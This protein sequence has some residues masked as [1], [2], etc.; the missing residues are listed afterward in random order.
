MPTLQI[1]S[2]CFWD[3]SLRHTSVNY[4]PASLGAK[5]CANYC[6]TPPYISVLME[7]HNLWHILIYASGDLNAIILLKWDLIGQLL[8]RLLLWSHFFECPYIVSIMYQRPAEQ[9]SSEPRQHQLYFSQ[10][11]SST[12][13]LSLI[14]DVGAEIFGTSYL[15]VDWK[16]AHSSS[17]ILCGP[18]FKEYSPWNTH[19]LFLCFPPLVKACV[20]IKK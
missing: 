11:G 8:S 6:M 2:T 1:T 4:Q 3:S 17:S 5:C 16:S 10:N 14:V 18:P 19:Y 20:K 12:V 13:K 7:I 9:T 15:F